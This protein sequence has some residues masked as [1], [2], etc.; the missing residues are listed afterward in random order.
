ME[1]NTSRIS[2]GPEQFRVSNHHT[3]L[4]IDDSVETV[5]SIRTLIR[6]RAQLQQEN[7]D[8]GVKIREHAGIIDKRQRELRD[9][10]SHVAITVMDWDAG[11][12]SGKEEFLEEIGVE[13][14]VQ[15][16]IATI[17]IDLP[18]RDDGKAMEMIDDRDFDMAD[19]LSCIDIRE[20]M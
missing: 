16:W 18:T 20:E 11:C 12:T 5:D 8:L 10:K 6:Q 15:T 3:E 4:T 17:K 19:E 1:S 14:P 13:V 9:F 2:E 7:I